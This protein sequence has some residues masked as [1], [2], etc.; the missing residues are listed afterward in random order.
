MHIDDTG[1]L[2]AVIVTVNNVSTVLHY[3]C[4]YMHV[5][6]KYTA[7]IFRISVSD[8]LVSS[9]PG[10]STSVIGRPS[11]WKL[12]P[13]STLDVQDFNPVPTAS[14]DPLTRLMNYEKRKQISTTFTDDL[15]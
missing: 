7:I 15:L 11:S 6:D 9:K 8:I 10:V 13:V 1:Q 12:L 14:C 4:V 2:I 3:L 5:V